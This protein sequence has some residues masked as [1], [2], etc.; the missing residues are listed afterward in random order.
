MRDSSRPQMALALARLVRHAQ[1]CVLASLAP[2]CGCMSLG[3]IVRSMQGAREVSHGAPRH[4]PSPHPPPL[5]SPI[6]RPDH[7]PTLT[8]MHALQGVALAFVRWRAP[9][10]RAAFSLGGGF[11]YLVGR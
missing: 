8:R 10:A 1:R 4:L 2:R 6:A 3:F 11:S 9:S 7:M 5:R